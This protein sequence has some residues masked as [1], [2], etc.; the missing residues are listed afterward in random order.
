MIF[1]KRCFFNGWVV[2]GGWRA[3]IHDEVN[4]MK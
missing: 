2:V 4:M 3:G 1:V